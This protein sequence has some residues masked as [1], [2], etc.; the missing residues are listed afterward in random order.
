[1]VINCGCTILAGGKNSRMEG[2]NKAFIEMGDTIILKR[3][4]ESVEGIFDEIIIVTNTF[5]DY[6]ILENNHKIISD[7]IRNIGPLGGIYS[8]LA[9][10]SKD[11]VFVLPCDMP[12]INK[13]VV[14][15]QLALFN[16]T[17]CDILVPRIDGFLEPLHSI[18]KTDIAHLLHEFIKK[19]NNYSIRS[20]YKEVHVEYVDFA[21]S[22]FYYKVFTNINTKEDL[23]RVK[24]EHLYEELCMEI[25]LEKK[26][27]HEVLQPLQYYNKAKLYK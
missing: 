18:Y 27:E 13:K 7:K 24:N 21:N 3:I 15:E 8:A 26:S 6:Y 17:N 12:F 25:E 11:A 22:Y 9:E 14:E 10:T 2:R 20:F 16:K 19:S 5:E 1:M 4:L 23:E